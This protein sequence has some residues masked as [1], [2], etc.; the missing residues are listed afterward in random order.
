MKK[1]KIVIAVIGAVGVLLGLLIPLAALRSSADHTNTLVEDLAQDRVS[2]KDVEAIRFL[3]ERP[4][5]GVGPEIHSVTSRTEIAELMRDFAS[6]LPE[7]AYRGHRPRNHPGTLIPKQMM[8]ILMSDGSRY[9]LHGYVHHNWDGG[10]YFYATINTWPRIQPA[11]DSKVSLK[12]FL[13]GNGMSSHYESRQFAT[14]I[15][16]HSP[17]APDELTDNGGPNKQVQP[18]AGKPGS[19]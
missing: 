5:F 2:A 13:F 10:D 14:F 3:K 12:R 18:I 15:G 17:Y 4:G 16:R 7:D 19:G 1:L 6:T 11:D 9:E 8:D